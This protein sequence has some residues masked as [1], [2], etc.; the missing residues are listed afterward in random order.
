MLIECYDNGGKTMDRY[1]V[2]Y[3][4]RGSWVYLTMS[5]NA[6]MPNG[7]NLCEVTSE[8]YDLPREELVDFWS[9]P[10]QV[11]K[12]VLLDLLETSLMLEESAKNDHPLG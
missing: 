5:K 11:R 9:L 3:P 10:P 7:V 1:T 2:V 12:A 8:R 4:L 6:N